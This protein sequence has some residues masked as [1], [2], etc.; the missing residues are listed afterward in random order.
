MAN[1]E[2]DKKK[3]RKLYTVRKN[4]VRVKANP[5]KLKAGGAKK[6]KKS[7]PKKKGGAG[8][9]KRPS[10]FN[11]TKDRTISFGEP[12]IKHIPKIDCPLS[13]R[14]RLKKVKLTKKEKKE[15]IKDIGSARRRKYK[16]IC[17]NPDHSIYTT[18][19]GFEC[20]SRFSV[21]KIKVGAKKK[22]G[23]SGRY[24]KQRRTTPRLHYAPIVPGIPENKAMRGW[25]KKKKCEKK[26]RIHNAPVEYLPIRA[27][28]KK[29]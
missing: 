22:G 18:K 23:T 14:P 25:G 6:K 4:M 16:K 15:E 21:K 24:G 26:K 8:I 28:R 11:V 10:R 12:E 2:K 17:P 27:G 13:R 5:I 9:I 7:K 1:K 20:C 29:K 19:G 3:K